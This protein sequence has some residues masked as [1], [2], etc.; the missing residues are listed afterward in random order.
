MRRLF[1]LTRNI[2]A[3]P[4]TPVAF[5]TAN[6]MAA[7]DF[8]RAELVVRAMRE[9]R[10]LELLMV[11]AG[12]AEDAVFAPHAPVL[13]EIFSLL[14]AAYDPVQAAQGAPVDAGALA[15]ELG[16]ERPAARPVRHANFSG[17]I[18]FRL[19]TGQDY[20]LRQ[21]PR[22]T[23]R[24]DLDAGK[25]ARRAGGRRPRAARYAAYGGGRTSWTQQDLGL[26]RAVAREFLESC[27][28][29]LLG[30]LLHD[31]RH[32]N[33]DRF[34]WQVLRLATWML[35]HVR[36]GGD[37]AM[38]AHVHAVLDVGVLLRYARLLSRFH[39]ER[40]TGSELMLATVVFF[41]EILRLAEALQAGGDAAQQR[42]A[43][44]IQNALFYQMDLL[45]RF[46]LI[47]GGLTNVA[48]LALTVETIHVVLKLLE[49]FC[50]ARRAGVFVQQAARGR[51]RPAGDGGDSSGA[52]LEDERVVERRFEFAQ[53]V[54]EF[55]TEPVAAAYTALLGLAPRSP[56]ALNRY[57]AV[58]LYRLY[59]GARA[60]DLFYKVSF[61]DPAHRLLRSTPAV[62]RANAPLVRVC[63][64]I[65]AGFMARLRLDPVL[66]LEAF[67]PYA[68]QRQPADALAADFDLDFGGERD[69]AAAAA[70]ADVVLPETLS[71]TQKMRLLARRLVELEMAPHVNWLCGLLAGAAAAAPADD[72]G[73]LLVQAG[74]DSQ[75]GALQTPTFCAL[76]RLVGVRGPTASTK[77]WHILPTADRGA[78]GGDAE[79]VRAAVQEA[80]EEANGAGARLRFSNRR[81]EPASERGGAPP[82][83]EASVASDFDLDG[84]SAGEASESEA[85]DEGRSKW[86]QML[87]AGLFTRTVAGGSEA[88][89][90]G[91]SDDD[92]GGVGALPLRID[93][94]EGA[95]GGGRPA[96]KR[97]RMR[98]ASS[99]DDDDG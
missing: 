37:R 76:L 50:S 63:R 70:A 4:D 11:A 12:S 68:P 16:R 64:G 91:E 88:A 85:G 92:D 62:Q 74:S 97:V 21:G 51:R 82:A 31:E 90:L 96:D 27:F 89:S 86:Q 95:G 54:A 40:R 3:V 38:V 10:L 18:V 94:E 60:E 72:A 36:A 84:L 30:R 28:N 83:S 98:I 99:S 6:G 14:F 19:S 17:S 71:R 49:R 2:L 41:R 53:F 24:L 46:R 26:V 80:V 9:A 52:E 44:D 69:T 57:L 77:H 48:A 13:C 1:A 23:D 32:L 20:V 75:K 61:L 34:H 8:G 81:A 58:M 47:L 25:A 33:D 79:Y 55:A 5:R 59:V 56:A 65:V 78:L 22:F 35:Q 15:E 7:A 43:A 93:D 39:E 42:A 73:P 45:Q 29:A 87:Q 67:F 66:A